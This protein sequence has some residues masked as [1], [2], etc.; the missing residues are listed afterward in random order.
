MIDSYCNLLI[1]RI[2]W[3]KE[4]V[5]FDKIARIVKESQL[6]CT[7]GNGGSSAT[8]SHLTNDLVKMCGIPSICLTDSVP[9][10]T[11]YS[12]DISYEDALREY[13]NDI[14]LAHSRSGIEVHGRGIVVI[15]FSGSGNSSNLVRL[16][17]HAL[18]CGSTVIAVTGYDESDNPHAHENLLV[19]AAHNELDML[20]A[21]AELADD[22]IIPGEGISVCFRVN[23]MQIAE[24][25]HIIWSHILVRTIMG[26]EL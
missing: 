4:N 5:P 20:C 13:Y 18:R 22:E 26:G 1:N 15:V 14:M 3:M 24:D 17:A 16:A 2:E 11:A 8:A 19:K 9:L 7:V 6:I 10:L 23:D 25:L 12:N 21:T